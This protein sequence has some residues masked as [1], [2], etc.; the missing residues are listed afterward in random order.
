M[1]DIQF[2]LL[3]DAK[4]TR[5]KAQR[6]RS[7]VTSV[8][9]V[10]SAIAIGL[11]AIL[12]LSVNVYQKKQMG[13]ADKDIVKYTAQ[14]KNVPKV[15]EAL[16]S[17]SQLVS[18]S[19][20]H[21]QKHISSRIFAYLP[22][23]TPS[24]VKISRVNLDFAANTLII[25]GTADSQVAINTFI[26]TLK[27]TTYK[28]GDKDTGSKAFPTVTESSFSIASGSVSFGLSLTF[29]PNLFSNTLNSEGQP[30]TPVLVVPKLT[31]THA[32]QDDPASQLFNEQGGQ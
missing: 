16:T 28:I 26:D 15:T 3:P 1:S 6:S 24:N 29:D 10:V 13:D 21:Q 11:F 17:Q 20:L 32:S 12:F 18:L 25:D 14:L 23:V 4:M 27:F 9:I 7:L 19:N 30:Q 22:Q 5:V 8:A 2:N 31:T